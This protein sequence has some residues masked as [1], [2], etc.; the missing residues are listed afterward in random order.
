M[1]PAS[2]Q[3][4]PTGRHILLELCECPRE[5]L[6]STEL[7][8]EI[9]KSCAVRGGATVVSANFHK[10]SPQGVSGVIVIAESHITIHT[11]PEHGYAAV[12]VFTCGHSVIA[13]QI[14]AL[15]IEDMKCGNHHLT[16]F[17]RQPPA[18]KPVP[19]QSS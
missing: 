10:F 12:D 4:Q 11:W 2:A 6:D 17:Q 5:L 14:A 9:L 13:D 16:A 19:C 8:G 15:V 18:P 1:T 3:P 7:I